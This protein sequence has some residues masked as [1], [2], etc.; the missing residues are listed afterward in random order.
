[1][2]ELETRIVDIDVDDIRNKLISLGGEKVKSEDQVN[3]I[4]DFEDGRLLSAKGYAR[5]RTTVDRIQGKETVF[6]TTKKMLSQDTFKV[7]EENEV[8]VDNKEMARR[9]FTSLGL[10]LQESISKYRESY[11]INDSL[12]EIDI[13][14]KSFC[15][16]PYLEIET[17]SVEKLEEIVKLLG[18]TL[19]DTTSQTIYDILAERGIQGKTKGR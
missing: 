13:N 14:D 10:K 8:I 1:M 6:M 5:I 17:T 16:F 19:E 18:Y 11:K 7:M 4:Y 12:V 2:K 15:P 9:I 3:E